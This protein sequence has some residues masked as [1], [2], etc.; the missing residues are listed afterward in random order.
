[1]D[2]IN[3]NEYSYNLPAERIA[4]YPLAERDRS[5]L[6]VYRAG[7]VYHTVFR[8]LPGIIPPRQLLV[9]N[10]TRVVQ[11]RL[12]FQKESGAR[13]EIFCLEPHDP[14]D[15]Y[16]AFGRQGSCTWKC[17]VGNARKWK[18]GIL[19]MEAGGPFSA[20]LQ[21]SP[22]GKTGSAFLVRFS[23]EPPDL[24]FSQVMETAGNTPIPP[25]LEREAE[26]DD[27]MRYQTVYAKIEGSVAAPTSGLHFTDEILSRIRETGNGFLETTL[28]I[29]AGTFQPV[30]AADIREH[31]MHRE[32]IYFSTGMLRSLISN[33]GRILAVGTTSVRTIE[34]LYWL[35]V[36]SM[37]YP[38][39]PDRGMVLD[40]WDAYELPGGY[41]LKESLTALGACLD[42]S[43][44]SSMEA[45]TQLLIM[46]GYRFRLV[47]RMI[48]NFHMPRSTLL[49]LVSLCIRGLEKQDRSGWSR[50]RS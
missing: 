17:L 10:N 33:E 45:V 47:N 26:D 1:M 24:S 30:A 20:V 40:Q 48:T 12:L 2:G 15:Y 4:R 39:I 9:F 25:Y 37:V 16:Q 38:D 13:I 5:K 46:P 3:I 28:H 29:G 42:K 36:K 8:N 19:K 32:R 49:L 18:E 35:G 31:N 44:R 43:G 27:R 41:S 21:A 11:A 34:S 50:K 22:E 7:Q 14:P 23:W 6:L